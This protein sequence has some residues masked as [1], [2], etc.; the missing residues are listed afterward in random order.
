M[1][2]LEGRFPWNE[3]RSKKVTLKNFV[4]LWLASQNK[5]LI[6]DHLK[7]KGFQLIE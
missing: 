4:F 6:V 3:I 1:F 5:I 7:K 2:E